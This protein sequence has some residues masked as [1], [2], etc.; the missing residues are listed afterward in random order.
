MNVTHNVYAICHSSDTS[1]LNPPPPDSLMVPGLY[2][3]NSAQGA[4]I[5]VDLGPS[6]EN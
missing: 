6:N 3:L 5:L 1:E 2:F 4:T